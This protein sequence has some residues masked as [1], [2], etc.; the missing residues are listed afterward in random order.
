MEAGENYRRGASREGDY[1]WL[2]CGSKGEP[3]SGVEG[4]EMHG[5]GR[6]MRTGMV[7]EYCEFEPQ[8]LGWSM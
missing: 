2:C 1:C 5:K 7:A 3:G 8:Y 6:C 4:G